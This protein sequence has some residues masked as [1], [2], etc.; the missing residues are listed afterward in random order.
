[1]ETKDVEQKTE[2]W[3]DARLK[4]VTASRIKDVIA[5][6]K[7]G[8]SSARKNYA[9]QLVCEIMTGKRQESYSNAAMLWGVEQEPNARLA[10]EMQMG[11]MVS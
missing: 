1:M 7:S 9:A 11:V 4:K 8:Y 2:E 6:T 10:Y 5:K 3:F